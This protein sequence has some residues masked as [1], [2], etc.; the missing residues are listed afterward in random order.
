MGDVRDV[1]GGSYFLDSMRNSG[2]NTVYAIA[3]LIDNSVE[4]KAKRIEVLCA[5]K[6]NYSGHRV[7]NQLDWL[8]VTDDG[9]GMSEEELWNSLLMGQGTRQNTGK[10]GKFGMGLP[11]SS[12]SQCKMVEVYSW[13]TPRKVF[14]TALD[15]DKKTRGKVVAPR[16]VKAKIP[17]TLMDKSKYLKSAKTGT[18]VLWRNLDKMQWM[19][20]S[21]VINNSEMVIGRIYRK[22]IHNDK[23]V[24]RMASFDNESS[25]P[26]IDKNM[27]PN[28]PLYQMTPSSAPEPWNKKK[29]FKPD[30]DNLDETVSVQG[31]DVVVR[32]AYANKESRKLDKRGRHAGAQPHGKHANANLGISLIRANRELYLDTNLCQTYDPLERWWGV[33]V[34]FPTILDD[35]FG[36]TNNKQDAVNFSGMTK[37]IGAIVRGERGEAETGEEAETEEEE[38]L[39]KLVMGINSRLHNMRTSIKNTNESASGG[40]TQGGTEP[41]PY[42][43]D[44]GGS[45]TGR[46]DETMTDKEKEDAIIEALSEFDPDGASKKA[47]YI[48]K[49]KIKANLSA[50]AMGDGTYDFFTVTF[51]GGVAFITLN[52]DHLVYKHLVE[53]VT[54]VPDNMSIEE[55]R[56]R[57][58]KIRGGINSIILSWAQLEDKELNPDN[59]GE[60]RLN[61][62]KWGKR[63]SA[64]IRSLYE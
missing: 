36:V 13:K 9:T 32:Y 18:I 5:E 15:L 1:F 8:A 24:I 59:R 6:Q 56:K 51:R 39:S 3:E 55:A 43:D 30:G 16:P 38:A 42:P 31:H 47:K 41:I 64:F 10:L 58:I 49:N 7:T 46:Q 22:F 54:D 48:L 40:T 61:R 17:Q 57:L 21:S 45:I 12:I 27:L 53:V 35:V 20:G 28:D 23:I 60:L 37:K 2:Y 62:M 34:D 25:K 50:A 4:A 63:L 52:K 33:E 11:N 29:M 14:F 19:K 44:G 26:K